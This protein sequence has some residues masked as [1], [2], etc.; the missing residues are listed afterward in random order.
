M[1]IVYLL[2]RWKAANRVYVSLRGNVKKR[3]AE[4][5]AG[6]CRTTSEKRPWEVDAVVDFSDDEEAHAL[7]LCFNTG[8]AKA[9]SRRHL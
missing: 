7:K 3:R 4:Y 8:S 5:N 2:R 9:F 6:Y 1:H